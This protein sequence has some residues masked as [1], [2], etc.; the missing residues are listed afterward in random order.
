MTIELRQID[1]QFAFEAIGAPIWSLFDDETVRTLDNT[2]SRHG[3]LV[4]RRQ[5]VSEKELVNFSNLFGAAE[6]IVR[7][8]WASANYPEVTRISNMRNSA[9]DPI[10]GLGSGELEWHTDQSYMASPATGAI[11]Y[12]VEVPLGGPDTM[13]ANL[14]LAYDTLPD[15]VRKTIDGR[16]G[17]FSY[18][19]RVSAY[20]QETTPE[21]VRQKTPDVYHPLV[22]THP[23]TGQ[24]AMYLDPATTVGIEG[25]PEDEGLSILQELA[26]HAASPAFVYR[27]VWQ[28]GDVIMWDNGFLLHRRDAFATDQNRLLKRTTIR[29]SEKR[30]ILPGS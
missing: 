8:D 1:G 18:A 23:E 13:W 10:G 28:P 5:S 3:V 16:R 17:I 6:K 9:G 24:K 12:G 30:H 27:H 7:A 14:A 22:N 11:L 2:L 21:E 20:D 26:I 19:K 4:F 25:I 15:A 29:L